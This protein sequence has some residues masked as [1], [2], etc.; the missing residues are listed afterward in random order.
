MD[1]R[2]TNFV[3]VALRRRRQQKRRIKRERRTDRP[4]IFQIERQAIFRQMN[5][6]DVWRRSVIQ[7]HSR[8]LAIRFRAFPES[9]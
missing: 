9:E 7:F 3:V 6:R 2:M 4:A 8:L 1:G 5:R